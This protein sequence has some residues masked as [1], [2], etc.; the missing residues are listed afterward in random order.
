[1]L[2]LHNCTNLRNEDVQHWNETVWRI[3]EIRLP[4]RADARAAAAAAAAA[5][6]GQGIEVDEKYK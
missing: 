4:H 2:D 6:G 3:P 1:M 5:L